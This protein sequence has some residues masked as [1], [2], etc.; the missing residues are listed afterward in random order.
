MTPNPSTDGELVSLFT[1]LYLSFFYALDCRYGFEFQRFK[2]TVQ[3]A[4]DRFFNPIV[5]IKYCCLEC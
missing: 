3:K 1:Y 5:S 2:I 4:S